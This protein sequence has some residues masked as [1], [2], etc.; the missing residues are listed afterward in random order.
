MIHKR[1]VE[2]LRTDSFYNIIVATVFLTILVG[3]VAQIFSGI[4]DWNIFIWMGIYL[5][6]SPLTG[7]WA[8]RLAQNSRQSL[9]VEIFLGVHLLLITI[10]IA[11]AETFNPHAI[12][13]YGYFIVVSST[14]LQPESSFNLWS[15]CLILL[16]GA[17]GYQYLTLDDP[18]LLID[19]IPAAAWAMTINLFL[20]LTGFLTTL[21]WRE[22]VTSTSVLQLRAQKRRDELF[23]IQEKL[24]RASDRQKALYT[25]LITSVEV[26]QRITT[27]L[28]RDELL[29]QVTD[30]IK[31]KLNF[32]YVGVFLLESDA[33]LESH[34][35]AGDKLLNENPRKRI[36]LNEENLLTV[37]VKRRRVTVTD[38]VRYTQFAV[39]P[40]LS[41]S[42]QSEIGLPL[43]IGKH[44]YGVLNIQSYGVNAFDEEILPILRLLRN[45]AAIALHNAQLYEEALAARQ[46]AEQANDIKSRFLASMSHE[47]RTPLNAILNFTGFVADGV[48]GEVNAEQADAL[49]KT[50]DSGGHL[51]SL[52]NDILDLAKVEAGA[53]EMFIQEIDMNHLLK[54]TVA[55]AHGLVK[56]KSIQLVLDIDE[57]L[58]Q[59]S[60]D[61]RRL[62][63]I[64]LNLV[65]NAVKYTKE[66]QIKLTACAVEDSIQ[67][68]VQDTGIGIAAE[69]QDFIFESFHQAETGFNELGTGLGLPIAKHFV[70]AHGG[71]IWLE[72]E[73]DVGTTFF[74]KV[75]LQSKQDH[76]SSGHGVAG[77][78]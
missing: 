56:N 38:D 35:Y 71:Q 44:L 57:N 10:N 2:Q 76:V 23:E 47:L 4:D 15:G 64:L 27:L 73:V 54:S 26:G 6:V 36:Y 46:E 5:V 33:F 75:P 3:I 17:F 7:R 61:K 28:E 78:V 20:A 49:E 70:E 37:T 29:Q 16:L 67:I 48:F 40:Y 8:W 72:S 1:F 9:G 14:L 66:G 24:R 77:R 55:T 68:S 58:P 60:G 18:T 69:D 11:Q 34:A 13:L 74:V 30:L 22:A 31:S 45:Q 62:R 21:D 19:E 41:I 39:H 12:Y 63:Q 42:T 50:L 59:I 51:L 32:S 52:I 53:M 43:I 65:S 25:Q